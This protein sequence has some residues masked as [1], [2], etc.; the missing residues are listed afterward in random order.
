MTLWPP[1]LDLKAMT[2]QSVGCSMSSS[3][4]ATECKEEA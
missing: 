3:A 1:D 2:E 4:I